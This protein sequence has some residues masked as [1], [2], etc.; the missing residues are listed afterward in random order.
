MLRTNQYVE[1]SSRSLQMGRSLLVP[2]VSTRS[3]ELVG[4]HPNEAVLARFADDELAILYLLV[5]SRTTSEIENELRFVGVLE[6]TDSINI[7]NNI[8]DILAYG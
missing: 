8:L 2:T 1:V 3:P 4:Y 7:L 5:E 6:Q